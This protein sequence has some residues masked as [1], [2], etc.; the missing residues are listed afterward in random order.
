[1][2]EITISH[3][4]WSGSYSPA[5]D[6]SLVVPRPCDWISSNKRIHWRVKADLTATW[7]ERAGWAVKAAKLPTLGRSRVIAELHMQSRR[8]SRVDPANYADTAKP[9]VDALVAVGKVWPDDSSQ[10]VVGPDMRLGPAV[11]ANH[12]ALV[13]HIW[14]IGRA[15]L[16]RGEG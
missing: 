16:E 5:P 7:L 15:A 13:L 11:A 14:D 4:V 10:W 2:S 8:R 3:N 12:E 9:C 6:H 1:M